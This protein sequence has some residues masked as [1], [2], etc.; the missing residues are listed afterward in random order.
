MCL[1]HFNLP[2]ACGENAA[3]RRLIEMLGH[4]DSERV[5]SPIDPTETSAE[6]SEGGDF[7]TGSGGSRA[8]KNEREENC[9]ISEK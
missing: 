5:G 8:G 4:T 3:V 2:I 7:E 1:L 9:T 6:S